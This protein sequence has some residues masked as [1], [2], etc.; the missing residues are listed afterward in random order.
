METSFKQEEHN[1]GFVGVKH[2]ASIKYSSA[3]SN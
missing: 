2:L 3:N 1:Q